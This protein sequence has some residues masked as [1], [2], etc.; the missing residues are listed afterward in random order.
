M[1]IL[2]VDNVGVDNELM[3]LMLTVDV[4]DNVGVPVMV[5]QANVSAQRGQ[6]LIHY[7]VKSSEVR[8]RQFFVCA[9]SVRSLKA[10]FK[11]FVE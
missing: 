5:K 1:M 2:K 10:A 7:S 11:S 4:D 9:F 3:M 6:P 8:L